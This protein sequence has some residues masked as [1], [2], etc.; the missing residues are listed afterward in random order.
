[1]SEQSCGQVLTKTDVDG[2][3]EKRR[4]QLLK[5]DDGGEERLPRSDTLASN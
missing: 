3:G 5:E 1:M 2:E 4:G